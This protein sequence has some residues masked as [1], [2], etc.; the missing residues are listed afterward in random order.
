M[1]L[2]AFGCGS[3]ADALLIAAPLYNLG[4]PAGLK[5]WLDHIY[6]DIRLFPGFSI[7]YPLAGRRCVVVTARGGAYGPGSPTH[8]WDYENPFMRR[9]LVDILGLDLT[10]I[11]VDLTLAHLDPRKAE[12]LSV[13]EESHRQGHAEAERLGRELMLEQTA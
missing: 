12:V 13:A 6:T 1:S 7:T 2:A 10:E 8:G 9:Q 5:S 11:V 3:A 4:I